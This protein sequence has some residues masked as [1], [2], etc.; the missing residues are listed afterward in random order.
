MAHDLVKPQVLA[1]AALAA[2]LETNIMVS[3]LSRD[4]EADLTRR[5]IGDTVDVRV[6]GTFEAKEWTPGTEVTYQDMTESKIQIKLDK[7]HDVSIKANALENVQ[8]ITSLNEQFMIPA[9]TALAGK[10]ERTIIDE[11]AAAA[12]VEVGQGTDTARPYVYTNPKTLIDA[13]VRLQKALAPASQ[14]YAVIGADMAGSWVDKLT[15]YSEVGETPNAALREAAVGRIQA[16]DVFQSTNILPPAETPDSGEPTT[17]VGIAFQRGAAAIAMGTLNSEVADQGIA[18][19]DGV[20]IRVTRAY[21]PKL[22][23][24]LYSFDVLW[25]LNVLRP[26]H[27]VLIKGADAS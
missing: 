9:M 4:Y 15:N 16:F 6:P 19:R 25:G 13:R 24:D 23:E 7:V 20:A 10:V 18:S 14:R 22:K 2:L 3:L 27:I 5:G 26:Q 17:E 1:N 21:E 12:T 8:S 11:L